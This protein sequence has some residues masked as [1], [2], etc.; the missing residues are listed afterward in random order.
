VVAVKRV[1]P[2]FGWPGPGRNGL[3]TA[4]PT[5]PAKTQPKLDARLRRRKVTANEQDAKAILPDPRSVKETNSYQSKGKNRRQHR[6]FR[7]C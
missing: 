5:H 4:L 2:G 1:G 3:K 7:A 6:Y